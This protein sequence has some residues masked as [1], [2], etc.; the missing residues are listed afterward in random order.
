MGSKT[1]QNKKRNFHTFVMFVK[2]SRVDFDYISA[3][4]AEVKNKWLQNPHPGIYQK[5]LKT[6][7]FRFIYFLK[8]CLIF[9]FV[10]G[11]VFINV[12]IEVLICLA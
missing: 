9:N 12:G 8:L 5:V 7:S 11:I 10:F 3:N 2:L 6:D 4:V 1:N